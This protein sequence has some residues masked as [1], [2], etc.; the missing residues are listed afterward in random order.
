MIVL[1]TSTKKLEIVLAGSVT[2]SQLEINAY[3]FD[4]FP[5]QQSQPA[6]GH[7][8]TQSNNTTDVTVVAA[9][10][11]QGIRRNVHTFSCYNKD[12]AS[13]IV[14]VKVD[15]GGTE[16]ILVK[17]T[18][19]S[20]DSLNYEHGAGWTFTTPVSVPFSDTLNI[21][22]G[23]ADPT[24]Q[25]RFEVDGLTTN[26]TRVLTVPDADLTIVGTATTQTLTNKTITIADANLTIQD[27]GDATKQ[28][29]FE[30][31]GITAGNTR[32]LTVPD[33]SGTLITTGSI[34]GTIGSETLIGSVQ[35]ASSSAQ[36]DFTS[37]SYAT[38]F[39]GSLGEITFHW[40]GVRPATDAQVLE[41][42]VGTGAGPTFDTASNY[43]DTGIKIDSS[44]VT[45]V[46]A[47]RS[48]AS[49]SAEASVGNS[50]TF[51]AGGTATLTPS[52]AGTAFH[53]S[54]R[55]ECAHVT[56]SGAT[57]RVIGT[58]RYIQ[59]TALTG[60]RF[61]FASGNIAEGKFWVTGKRLA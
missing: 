14:T 61:K 16:R 31:S 4:Q 54:I 11:L 19:N 1:D 5:Q 34:T 13:A 60:I 15:D 41:L 46:G 20:G 36:I 48:Y 59:T 43:D 24:K 51:A 10:A 50:S 17:Q 45:V 52:A 3:Y 2:T 18:L 55:Y 32:T 40:Q 22:K 21:V 37:A 39:D 58:C 38:A 30:L 33:A 25:I 47:V 49:L 27:N 42:Q 29:V 12:T 57:Q 56:S 9:P 7:K 28:A 53:K 8:A 35:T 23:S 6:S 44:G 26:T